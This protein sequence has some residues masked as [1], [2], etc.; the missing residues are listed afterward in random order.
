MKGFPGR[1]GAAQVYFTIVHNKQDN[2]EPWL[3]L[4]N[5]FQLYDQ[6]V[7]SDITNSSDDI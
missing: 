1:P 5:L 7:K 6:P 4:Q 2:S 3:Y